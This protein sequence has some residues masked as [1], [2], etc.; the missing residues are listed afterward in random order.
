VAVG[1]GIVVGTWRVDGTADMVKSPSE[2]SVGIARVGGTGSSVGSV[3]SCGGNVV[4]TVKAGALCVKV[5]ASPVCS[6]VSG[7]VG[8]GN[9]VG[10]GISVGDVGA[11]R[12]RAENSGS[13]MAGIG[14]S[15]ST[16]RG[17]RASRGGT[18]GNATI[19]SASSR[20]VRASRGGSIGTA[21]ISSASPARAPLGGRNICTTSKSTSMGAGE[22]GEGSSVGT[23]ISVGDDGS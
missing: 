7:D 15:V 1:T 9:S 22:V 16:S 21:T 23:G 3:G 12:A 13:S 20:G 14:N 6:S 10:T 19:S 18:M 11:A 5:V 4:G 17:V 2:R 8:D